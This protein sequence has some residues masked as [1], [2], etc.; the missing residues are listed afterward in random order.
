MPEE[1]GRS[2]RPVLGQLRISN[3]DVVNTIEI[4]GGVIFDFDL[5]A[6][7]G[8][9]QY[10]YTGAKGPL[11]FLDRRFDVRIRLDFI[12]VLRL[13]VCNHFLCC[14]FRLA[15]GPSLR[16]GLL[17]DLSLERGGR[18]GKKTAG[19]AG[20]KA[21]FGDE[22]LEVFRKL[23]E[24]QQV[25]NGSAVFAGPPSELFGA[26]LEFVGKP[27]ESLGSLYWI[28]IL[29]LNILDKR[30]FEEILVGDVANYSGNFGDFGEFGG[31]PTTFSRDQLVTVSNPA[32][33]QWLND[34]VGPNRLGKF[35]E[36]VVLENA[37][38]LERIWIDQVYRERV[39][40]V[41]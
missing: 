29:A 6:F 23:E 13:A 30:D 40:V 28:E 17:G 11:H 21:P 37:P 26:E 27:R 3:D 32:D 7:F 4:F 25:G 24:T 18:Q 20:G 39:G 36:T 10:A 38:R 33:D 1:K 8:L 34:A 22:L 2:V 15:D 16:H 31:S 14:T 19:M 5:A 12:H 41:C 9:F 35:H